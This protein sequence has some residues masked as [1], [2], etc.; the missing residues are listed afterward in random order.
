MDGDR[1]QVEAAVTFSFSTTVEG[2]SGSSPTAANDSSASVSDAK[3]IVVSPTKIAA[4]GDQKLSAG[5]SADA[6]GASG[7]RKGGTESSYRQER[8][9]C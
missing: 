1:V 5:L 9:D 6:K 7:E 8:T 4:A 3:P 2:T